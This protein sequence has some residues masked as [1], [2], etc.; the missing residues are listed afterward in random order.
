MKLIVTIVLLSVSFLSF[1]QR[2]QDTLLKELKPFDLANNEN[3]WQLAG[4][5][6]LSDGMGGFAYRLD[7]SGTFE[8]VDFADFGGSNISL[9]GAVRLNLKGQ[10]ELVSNKGT[11]TFVIFLFDKF[12]FLVRP[13]KIG[14]FRKDFRKIVL[15]AAKQNIYVIEDKKYSARFMVAFCL[16]SKY[17]V[18]GA[19]VY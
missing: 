3:L 17:L 1:G 15:S 10:L 9:K 7:S 14:D 6:I 8:R 5:F 2:L 19:Y 16:K 11:S 18:R 4:D 12:A 13:S